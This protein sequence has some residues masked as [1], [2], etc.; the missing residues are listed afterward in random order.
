VIAR[1]RL[2][3]INRHRLFII[4]CD[5]AEQIYKAIAL[6]R[7][8]INDPVGELILSDKFCQNPVEQASPPTR[9]AFSRKKL[10]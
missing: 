9:R 4:M 7:H 2:I 8:E 10:L 3:L 1:D 5:R 6:T